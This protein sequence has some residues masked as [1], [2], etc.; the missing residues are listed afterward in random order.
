M[1]LKYTQWSFWSKLFHGKN[2]RNESDEFENKGLTTGTRKRAKNR[3]TVKSSSSGTIGMVHPSGSSVAV[4]WPMD[5]SG[6]TLT[7]LESSGKE[8]ETNFRQIHQQYMNKIDWTWSHLLL[9]INLQD[10]HE[11]DLN[12]VQHLLVLSSP[13]ADRLPPG[14][15][16]TH[17]ELLR[18][19]APLFD[20][21]PEKIKEDCSHRMNFNTSLIDEWL[22]LF[23]YLALNVTDPLHVLF[24]SG[25]EPEDYLAP[26]EEKRVVHDGQRHQ[27]ETHEHPSV[28]DEDVSNKTVEIH[29]G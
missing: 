8:C 17:P 23:F 18:R 5:T 1:R 19:I 24:W 4:S 10:V 11:I 13:E 2:C 25:V 7:V 3:P 22:E 21:G 26:D 29:R 15:T 14:A 9:N 27:K 6:S 28:V 16:S 20:L 12:I